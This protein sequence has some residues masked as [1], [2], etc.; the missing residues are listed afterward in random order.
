MIA[1]SIPS[2]MSEL[3][4]QLYDLGYWL[5]PATCGYPAD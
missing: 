4:A 3:T 5:R 2:L 1:Y